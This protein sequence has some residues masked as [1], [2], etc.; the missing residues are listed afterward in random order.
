[1]SYLRIIS[2]ITLICMLTPQVALAQNVPSPDREPLPTPSLMPGEKDP[3]LVISP[4][5]KGQ[6]SAPIKTT[7]GWN[8]FKVEDFRNA[9]AGPFESIKAALEEQMKKEEIKKVFVDISENS[10]VEILIKSEA[11]QIKA[12]P[13]E[14]KSEEKPAEQK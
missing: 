4:M 12:E 6:I 8:I 1:M 13:S 14:Q 10:K 3:G 2:I 5:K 11:E 9:E 7:Y